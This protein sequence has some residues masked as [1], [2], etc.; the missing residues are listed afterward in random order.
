MSSGQAAAS[1]I[2]TASVSA[3]ATVTPIGVS[4]IG[5]RGTLTPSAAARTTIV[6]IAGASGAGA[7]T[8]VVIDPV[9]AVV[10]SCPGLYARAMHG[11]ASIRLEEIRNRRLEKKHHRPVKKGA[12]KG[13]ARSLR[14]MRRRRR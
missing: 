2:G 11:V 4:T 1:G 12:V 13:L 10:G 6:G 8:V 5:Q 7:V 3:R 14:R 9:H